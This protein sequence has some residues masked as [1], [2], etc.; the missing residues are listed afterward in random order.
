MRLCHSTLM[1]SLLLLWSAAALAEDKERSHFAPKEMSSEAA[2]VG[3]NSCLRALPEATR[4]QV[5]TK[6]AS[7]YCA[8]CIDAVRARGVSIPMNELRVCVDPSNVASNS[9]R[10]AFNAKEW[11]TEAIV[12]ATTQCEKSYEPGPDKPFRTANGIWSYCACFTDAVRAKG[13][14]KVTLADVSFC[15]KHAQSRFEPGAK[16]KR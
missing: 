13:Q 7:S 5:G 11:S 10:S 8:C 2:W 16:P 9:T 15:V 14:D 6:A 12:V 4:A 1:I 3:W